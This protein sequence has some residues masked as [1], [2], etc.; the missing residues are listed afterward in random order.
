MARTLWNIYE[1]ER[2][3]MTAKLLDDFK[4]RAAQDGTSP[5]AALVR[6]IQR[7]LVRGFDDQQT[8]QPPAETPS[9]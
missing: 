2:Q 3:G 7:Y 4:R 6:I 8:G 5:T 9:R 1:S